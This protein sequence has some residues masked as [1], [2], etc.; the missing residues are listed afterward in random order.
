MS[1][2]SD[3]H[4]KKFKLMS[5]DAKEYYLDQNDERR[6]EFIS[7]S[8]KLQTFFLPLPEEDK[9]KFRAI[10][11]PNDQ[12]TDL[13]V[14]TPDEGKYIILQLDNVGW[15][16]FSKM[17]KKQYEMCISLSEPEFRVCYVYLERDNKTLYAQLDEEE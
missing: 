5:D 6:A 7:L 12:W 13:L 17:P 1:K 11:A 10:M 4:K 8:K 9:D 14:D 15:D 2:V 3:A 16:A